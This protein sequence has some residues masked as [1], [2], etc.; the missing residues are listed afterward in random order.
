ME[1]GDPPSA[2]TERRGE[3]GPVSVLLRG[4]DSPAALF[5]AQDQSTVG[6]IERD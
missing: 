2:Q 1:S 6:L 4:W 3:A 5:L